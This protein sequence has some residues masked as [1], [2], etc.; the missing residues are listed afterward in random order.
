M[1]AIVY[2]TAVI[3][4]KKTRDQKD[5]FLYKRG[6]VSDVC[7]I[8]LTGKIIVLAGKDGKIDIMC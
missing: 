7:T 4:L 8:V 3:D 6:K 5:D 2:E 1:Q